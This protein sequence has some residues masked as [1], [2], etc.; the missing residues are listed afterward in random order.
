MSR[1]LVLTLVGPDRS[2]LVQDLADIVERHGGNW[3]ESRM[4][5]LSGQFAGILRV[6]CPAESAKA[7][8]A[9]L[10]E[11]KNLHLTLVPE[12]PTDAAEGKVISLEIVGHDQPGIVKRIA[13]TLSAHGAN[14]EEL[15]TSLESAPMAGHLLFRTSGKVRLAPDSDAADLINALEELGPDLTVDLS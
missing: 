15:E 10:A 9:E 13:S 11:F 6:E 3:L 12:D 2:G 4:A 8:E 5:K 14:V 7:L 1:V